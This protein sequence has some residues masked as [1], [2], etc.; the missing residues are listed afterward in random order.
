MS[1]GVEHWFLLQWYLT[2]PGMNSMKDFGCTACKWI[3][4]KK[5]MKNWPRFISLN[6]PFWILSVQCVHWWSADPM[7]G[8]FGRLMLDFTNGIKLDLNALKQLQHSWDNFKKRRRKNFKLF[9]ISYIVI[10]ILYRF[11]DA[12]AQVRPS[13]RNVKEVKKSRYFRKSQK[14][15][16]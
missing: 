11:M 10:L 9:P 15:Q 1:F 16:K 14:W 5:C 13:R 6:A 4:E 2:T 7:K 8:L 12:H 3:S